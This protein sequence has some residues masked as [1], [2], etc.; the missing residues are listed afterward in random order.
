MIPFPF[1]WRSFE[2]GLLHFQVSF[3]IEQ[4]IILFFLIFKFSSFF[5]SFDP[6]IFNFLGSRSEFEMLCPQGQ[7]TANVIINADFIC[8]LYKFCFS[9][10]LTAER[11][12]DAVFSFFSGFQIFFFFCV[13]R[14]L[15][16][17]VF[18]WLVP[19]MQILST[20]FISFVLA[21]LQLL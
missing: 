13:T 16:F 4:L 17:Q 5:A 2:A 7:L 10:S 20:S 14:P 9:S 18:S 12:R 15:C 6:T 21:G 8:Q 19:K 1:E 3:L 11:S